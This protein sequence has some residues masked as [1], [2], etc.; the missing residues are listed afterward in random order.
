[1]AMNRAS[2]PATIR[3]RRASHDYELGD[4]LVVGLQLSGA[5]TK[6]LRQGH[7]HLRGAYVTVKNDELWL[8]NATITGN[9]GIP[10]DETDKTRARKVLAKRREIDALIA[11]KQQGKTIVPLEILTRGRYIKLRISVGRGQKRYD[12]RQVLK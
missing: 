2:S 9:N 1:M 12:K 7:G 8:I 3:N 10:I 11:A 4:S 5:E 6:S